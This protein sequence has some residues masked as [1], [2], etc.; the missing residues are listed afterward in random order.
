VS[1]YTFPQVFLEM[2]RTEACRFM[3]Q[4]FS[5]RPAV[6]QDRAYLQA[7]EAAWLEFQPIRDA[8]NA[9]ALAAEQAERAAMWGMS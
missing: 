7:A 5:I 6:R 1:E 4:L 9:D 8:R 2:N 3:H